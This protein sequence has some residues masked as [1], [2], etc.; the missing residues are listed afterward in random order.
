VVEFDHFKSQ[1]ELQEFD[2]VQQEPYD[3]YYLQ[4]AIA[5]IRKSRDGTII[6]QT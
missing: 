3:A 4:K 6:L 1:A 5:L 2:I